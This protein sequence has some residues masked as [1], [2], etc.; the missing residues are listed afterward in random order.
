MIVL[1]L[2]LHQHV[3]YIHLHISPYLLREHLIYQPL[4]YGPYILESERNKPVAI[5]PSAGDEGSLLL[6]LFVHEAQKLMS[7][8]ESTS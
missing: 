1:I 7:R 5:Q 3:V 4:V 8:I 6:I 2:A